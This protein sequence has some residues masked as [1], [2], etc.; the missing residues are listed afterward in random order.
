M[1]ILIVYDSY[2]GNTEQV[3]KAIGDAL[4]SHGSVEIRRVHDV[5]LE[6]LQEVDLVIVGSPTRAFR[7]SKAIGAFLDEI[8][9]KGLEGVRVLAFD[10]RLH[11]AETS[12]RLFNVLS[13]V[14]G[15]AACPIGEKL[16]RKGGKLLAPPEGFFVT[17]SEGPLKDDELER[18]A[19]WALRAVNALGLGNTGHYPHEATGHIPLPR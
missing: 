1:K 6:Q 13:A 19:D 7:P 12:S 18:A 4:R 17:D 8:P 9:P 11:A 2:F 10:T 5:A 3:A 14:F 16:K 15:C